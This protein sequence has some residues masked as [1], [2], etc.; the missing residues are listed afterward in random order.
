MAEEVIN[1]GISWLYDHDEGQLYLKKKK[2]DTTE[3][4]IYYKKDATDILFRR[5][6]HIGYVQFGCVKIY[7]WQIFFGRSFLC[8]V[9]IYVLSLT[10]M[11]LSNMN[12]VYVFV[13]LTIALKECKNSHNPPISR[14]LQNFQ[15]NITRYCHLVLSMHI[16]NA[17]LCRQFQLERYRFPWGSVSG[18]RRHMR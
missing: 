5:C 8:F 14:N 18:N 10:K 11:Y 15:W 16:S 2:A 9:Y 7:I 1:E 4:C 6:F 3:H 13:F 17:R 12:L